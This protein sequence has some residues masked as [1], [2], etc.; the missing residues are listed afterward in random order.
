PQTGDRKP[1]T[2]MLCS[3]FRA[4]VNQINE[5]LRFA[6]LSKK[7][8]FF[9]ITKIGTVH[10][11]QGQQASIMVLVLGSRTGDKG[12]GARLWATTPPNLINVAVSRG[13]ET[14]IVI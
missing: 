6:Q 3:P 8:E 10:T 4:Q 13:I 14:L 7:N 1:K 12:R 5:M 9:H 11:M 2:I